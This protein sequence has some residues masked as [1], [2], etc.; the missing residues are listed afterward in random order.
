MRRFR[1]LFLALMVVL[2]TL[3]SRGH[4]NAIPCIPCECFQ[5][6]ESQYTSCVARCDGNSAC[7]TACQ[8]TLSLCDGRC[9][10]T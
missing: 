5:A 1:T 2:I 6:C 8:T 7:D 4:A 9:P 10:R 3:A